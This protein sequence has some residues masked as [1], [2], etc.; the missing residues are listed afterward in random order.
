M[1][2]SGADRSLIREWLTGGL[3]NAFASGILNPM[4]VSKTRMQ[5]QSST[6]KSTLTQI[7]RVLYRDGGMVG[8]WH[9]G[10]YPTTLMPKQ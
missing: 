10:I 1:I 4:D 8:L 7:L 5:L 2:D 6:E 3:A 9:P